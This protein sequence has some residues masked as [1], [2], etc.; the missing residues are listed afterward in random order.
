MKIS[1]I[2]AMAVNRVIGM[3]NK[4]PWY[5]SADLKK[6]KQIT[7]GHPI[8]MG[9]KTFESI[10]KPL[11]GRINIVITRNKNYHRSGCQ[12]FNEIDRAMGSCL[13]YDELFVIGGSTLYETILPVADCLYLTLIHQSFDGDTFFPEIDMTQWHEIVREDITNDPDVSFD[14]S[15]ITLERRDKGPRRKGNFKSFPK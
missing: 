9:R 14:Y 4:M 6:F 13:D 3:D 15:F 7:M 12:V 2:V 10:G 8:L 11:P 5:L 1:I